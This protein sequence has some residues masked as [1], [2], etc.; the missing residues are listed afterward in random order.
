MF[1]RKL[2]YTISGIAVVALLV[3]GLGQLPESRDTVQMH[4]SRGDI[5]LFRHDTPKETPQQEEFTYLMREYEE[6]IAIFLI[7]EEMPFMVLDTRV[8]FLPD[9][10]R[11]L[12]K[13][14]ILV[15]DKEQLSA[16]IEDY[17]S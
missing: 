2:V 15:R 16:L 5:E 7:G 9:Y 17:I 3:F 10:D 12:L 1:D 14:G 4:E 11:M 8:G 6:H 13:T